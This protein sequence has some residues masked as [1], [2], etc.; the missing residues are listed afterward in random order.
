MHAWNYFLEDPSSVECIEGEDAILT[1]KV[2]PTSLPVEWLKDG[3][4]VKLDE[5]CEQSNEGTKHNLIIKNVKLDDSGKYCVKVG[6]FSRKIHLKIE[7][8]FLEDPSSVE[9]IEGEDALLTCK[10]STTSL[11]VEWL[12]DGNPVKLD[13]NC[14]Q[15]NDGTKHNLIIKNVKSDDSGKYCVKVGNFSR[16]LQLKIEDCFLEDPSSV[17]YTE[18]EDAIL[19]CKVSTT[20]LPVQWLKDGKSVKLDERCQQ[21]NDGTT[22]NL[23]IKNVKSDDSGK[24]CVKVGNFSR[25]IQLKIEDNTMNHDEVIPKHIQEQFERRLEQWKKDDQQFVSTEAEKHIACNNNMVEVVRVLL[26]SDNVEIDHCNKRGSS[27]LYIASQNGHVNVVKELL[28]HSADVNKCINDGTPPLQ[29]ACY[30]NMIEVVR[31]LLQCDD[32]DID[33]CDDDGCS[34]LYQAS[35]EGHVDV[36]KEL[37]QHSADVNK[38]DND[39]ASPLYIASQNGHVDVVKE[40][41]QHSADVNKCRNDGTP[42]LQIACNNNMIE[43]VRVL[44]Q[45]DNVEIDHCNKGDLL[46]FI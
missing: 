44:L 16:K 6:N 34:S 38:C 42:P 3:N 32:V 9:Y 8:C 21:S 15:S 14:L 7:D 33:L 19:T 29:I 12:K 28:Q 10:I 4:D 41:L 1:C 35:Q 20:S 39:G 11:P 25:K 31:V 2:S 17:E 5:N 24:Y 22:H 18:G 23:V 13:D 43:V 37:L 27:S 26:Q 40:L 46:H 45:C 36:V 30:N